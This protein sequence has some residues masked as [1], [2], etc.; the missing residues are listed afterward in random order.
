ML[1]CQWSEAHSTPT[2]FQKVICFRFLINSTFY[3]VLISFGA[4]QTLHTC[5]FL[6]CKAISLESSKVAQTERH[7]QVRLSRAVPSHLLSSSCAANLHLASPSASHALQ[8]YLSVLLTRKKHSVQLPDLWSIDD[9]LFHCVAL[10]PLLPLSLTAHPIELSMGFPDPSIF[11]CGK[12]QPQDSWLEWPSSCVNCVDIVIYHVPGTSLL[13]LRAKV[14]SSGWCVCLFF[15]FSTRG[16]YTQE[17]TNVHS[18]C[19]LIVF[20]FIN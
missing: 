8:M 13:L 5:L 20:H 19:V 16:Q 3:L 1:Q 4:A 9:T 14:I 6:F 7:C 17:S 11:W 18:W 12:P 15:F 2:W 10:P